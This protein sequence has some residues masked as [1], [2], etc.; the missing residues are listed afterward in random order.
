MLDTRSGIMNVVYAT[1]D[2]YSHPALISIKSLLMNNIDAEQINIYYVENGISDDNKNLLTRLVGEYGRN[3]TFIKMPIFLNAIG[4]L[5]K[6]NPIVYSY[7]YFQDILPRYVDKILLLEGDSIVTGDLSEYFDLPL[8]DYYLAAA[9]DFQSRWYKRKLGMQDKSVYFNSGIMLFNLK[10]WREDRIT[11]KISRLIKEGNKKF[12]YEVQDE[13]NVLFENKVL[14]LPPRF[15]CT[16]A[17]FL[18][19]YK[20]MLLYRRPS[21]RC[22]EKEYSKGR[23]KPL[24]VHFTKNQIIQSRPWIERC[25]HPYND[26][27]ISIKK[28]TELK[29]EPLWQENRGIASKVVYFFYSHGVRKILAGGLGIVH[30]YLYPAVFYKFHKK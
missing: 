18:F 29:N 9:D 8:D 3:I 7:C 6:T 26:Y 19:E 4:G 10:K 24:I 14:I 12:F 23:E 21:T 5:L 17:V 27:Y 1:S 13:M 30:A 28:Q 22:T 15:N 25:V 11:E 20:D 16:T 2:L